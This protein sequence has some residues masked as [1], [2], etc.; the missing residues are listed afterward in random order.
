MEAALAALTAKYSD[1][2]FSYR[3]L[4]SGHAEPNTAMEPSAPAHR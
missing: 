1:F 4:E 3:V 2:G